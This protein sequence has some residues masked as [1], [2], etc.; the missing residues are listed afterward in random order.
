MSNGSLL[1]T[2]YGD[3]I[4]EQTEARTPREI[5]RAN[6]LKLLVEC[7]D[8]GEISRLDSC[9]SPISRA[10]MKHHGATVFEMNSN[11]A[12][13]PQDWRCPCCRRS[14][15]EISRVGQH[16]QILA[17]S[18]AHHDHMGEVLRRA[19][20]D[21]FV[22]SGMALEQVDGLELVRRMSLA[23]SAYDEILICEDCNNADANA[24]RMHDIPKD[25]SF[26]IGQ[27][28]SFITVRNHQ[29]HSID[30]ENAYQ[31]WLAAE[32]A[33]LLRMR[34]VAAVA[35]AAA[36][37][38]HWY[39]P[40]GKLQER[41]PV[42]GCDGRYDPCLFDW[43]A[44]TEVL[45]ALGAKTKVSKPNLRKWRTDPKPPGKPLPSN[46]LALLL[47]DSSHARRWNGL[48]HDWSCPVCLRSKH[49][50]VYIEKKGNISWHLHQLPK[51]AGNWGGNGFICNHCFSTLMSLKSEI[52]T[53]A[54]ESFIIYDIV[55]PAEVANIIIPR[56]HSLHA[57]KA[58][59]A[60]FLV[61]A[62]FS[63]ERLR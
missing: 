34:I 3:W 58:G 24:K 46:Y 1:F 7:I 28:C 4:R 33:Y 8:K 23:F 56:P 40:N 6:G 30:V 32:K 20:N 15:L 49:D 31:A 26:S 63:E 27:I 17:K 50:L 53:Y 11:W 61:K 41:Y 9:N 13:S 10:I 21:Q 12:L 38:R 51:H 2:R 48:A 19:F 52:A 45:D 60:D 39:E 59:N 5:I 18:V 47:S 25:F 29:A 35:K 44:T 55:T 57:I 14:K 62:I 42:L 36:T 37:D 43:F 22:A 16:G 54:N